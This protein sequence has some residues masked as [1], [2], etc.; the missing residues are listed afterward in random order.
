MDIYLLINLETGKVTK[1]KG[2][3]ARMKKDV[4]D[5]ILHVIHVAPL[6]DKLIMLEVIKDKG[7]D[8]DGTWRA[9]ET[10]GL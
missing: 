10:D 7:W 4:I 6:G 8:E 5:G 1:T 9:V 2:L 3:D